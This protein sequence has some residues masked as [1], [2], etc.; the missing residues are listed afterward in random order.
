VPR[1]E[2]RKGWPTRRQKTVLW[3]LR[4]GQ[5]MTAADIGVRSDVLW[6]ME[7]VGWVARSVHGPLGDIWYILP[8]GRAVSDRAA[9][10]E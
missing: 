3:T 5:K 1:I 9:G 7:E 6:R 10:L 8:A 4:M 2:A